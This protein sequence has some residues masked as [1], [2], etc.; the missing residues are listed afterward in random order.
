MQADE[1]AA[2][3]RQTCYHIDEQNC[4][5]N[6]MKII[7]Q[8]RNIDAP[9]NRNDGMITATARLHENKIIGRSGNFVLG[10]IVAAPHRPTTTSDITSSTI[11]AL[12]DRES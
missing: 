1:F 12:Q 5:V 11:K 3:I 9:Q 6:A 4:R 7:Q 8:Q 10:E 2:T